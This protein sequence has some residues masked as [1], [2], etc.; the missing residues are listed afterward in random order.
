MVA[1]N[2]R[3][4]HTCAFTFYH[5]FRPVLVDLDKLFSLDGHLLGD[6]SSHEHGLETRPEKLHLY[7]QLQAVGRVA[8]LVQLA[9]FQ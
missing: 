8:Q 4:Q 5:G 3:R 6:I 7:P 1:G 2:Q 9:L